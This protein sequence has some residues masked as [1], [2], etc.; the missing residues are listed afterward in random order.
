MSRKTN[1]R[2][3]ALIACVRLHRH[4]LLN[5][6][7]LPCKTEQ[8][9][10]IVPTP[11]PLVK[12]NTISLPRPRP[13]TPRSMIKVFAYPLVQ[14][15]PVF[16]QH[17]SVLK[18]NNR[19]LCILSQ[20]PLRSQ[21]H[22][23]LVH[24][25]L[26]S[27]HCAFGLTKEIEISPSRWSKCHE[28]YSIIMNLRWRRKRSRSF[29]TLLEKE[30]LSHFP[31][32]SIA[33]MTP[34]NNLD[35]SRLDRV[36]SDYHRDESQRFE[37]TNYGICDSPKIW[38]PCYAPNST[39]IVVGAHK[40][41]R[42]GSPFPEDK[43]T[44]FKEYYSQK[45]GIDISEQ[46]PMFIAHHPWEYQKKD[47]VKKRR[48][49]D[50]D[51]PLEKGQICEGLAFVLLPKEVS[52]EAPFC[53]AALYLHLIL[54]PQILYELERSETA[55]SFVAY[56][57]DVLP[58][59]GSYLKNVDVKEVVEAMTARS[60]GKKYS[61]D[62]MEY[63]GDAVLKLL[64]TDSLVHAKDEVV[65][66]WLDTLEEG[67]LST[68]RSGMGCN[69]RLTNVCESCGIDQ[70]ILAVPFGQSMWVPPGLSRDPNDRY[71]LLSQIAFLPNNKGRCNI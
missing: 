1:E 53:D 5:D 8:I 14:S 32:F 45:K 20:Q 3:L 15:G 2:L 16:E 64:Q 47:T 11:T 38:C 46:S 70:Y 35:W 69:D 24:Y 39:Y 19:Y 60:S 54:L 4:K 18:G 71:E 17:D 23:D 44:S 48:A 62:R 61:Y 34:D 28:F 63:L 29:L 56:C 66:E 41:I 57:V 43:F 13:V 58:V 21:L 59:L 9:K 10:N 12:L 33:C 25:E 7:L 50:E 55:L 65:K 26:G 42:C 30:E 49:R 27:V 6:Q 40:T 51:P 37:A 22:L 36:I 68:I 31:I 52:M 67:E